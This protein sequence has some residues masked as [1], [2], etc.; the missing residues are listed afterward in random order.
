MPKD[1]IVAGIDIGTTKVVA[2]VA[3]VMPEGRLNIIGL[4]ETPSGGLRKG[5]IVDI[6]NT[7]RAIAGAIEQAERMSGCQVHSAFVGLTGPHIDSLNNRGVVAVTGEDGEISLEDVER[8]L[9][10]ARVIPLAAERRIIHVLPRQYIVDGYDGVMDPVGM[11][12]SRLEVETQIVTA[13]GAAVQNIMKSVQRAGLAVDELVLNP[14][15]SAGAVLQQA[16]RELGSVVVD[17]GG[18]TTEIALISQGSLWFAS[19]LPIGSEHITSDLAVGLRTPIV[20]AEVIK[21]EY[22]C[23]PA[24]AV[25]DN[26]AVEVPPVGGREKR[27]VSRKALAAIIEPRVEEIFTLVRRELSSAHFQGLLPGGVVLTGGGALLEGITGM[28]AE[29]LA[30]PVR[31]GWP[32]G[33]SGL[34]DMV[35]A[36]P[37]ATAV[38]LV[39]YGARRLAHPQAAATRETGWENFWSRLKSWWREL[40]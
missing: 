23:V 13:A 38:G 25:P 1:N 4:G 40:F 32:E 30:M 18:G 29:I 16:E 2:V 28:A 22:G 5:I 33:G 9:Q 7:S 11:C 15:A 20:Q 14:L 10:A 19:V 8:V 12:G 35:A 27:R 36:P 34:A 21:K 31:L 26:E 3:E 6:E 17:I 24:D 39:N 37:Y